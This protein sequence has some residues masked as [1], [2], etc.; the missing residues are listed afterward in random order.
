MLGKI[1]GRWIRGWQ[2]MRRLD[3]ITDLM[4]M[5]LRKLQELVMEREAWHAAFH[6]VTN[7]WT[8]LSNWTDWQHEMSFVTKEHKINWYTS[9][10][11]I[12]VM[13]YVVLC[14]DIQRYKQGHT[15][16]GM[17]SLESPKDR[18]AWWAVIHR[19]PRVGHDLSDLAHSTLHTH[20][21]NFFIHSLI[22]S[23]F[24]H[25][26]NK[27]LLSTYCVSGIIFSLK[28]F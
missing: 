21:M 22:H 1:E 9:I 19:S 4:D 2:R 27:C 17:H 16:G 25:S 12:C 13:C 20:G 6:G 8:W 3:G 11:I 18:G 24:I 14:S 10:D 26:F 7:S 28:N 23:N 15:P 5:S